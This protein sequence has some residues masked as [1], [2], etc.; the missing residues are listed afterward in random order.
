MTLTIEVII[1]FII[2]IPF[3]IISIFI[4]FGS[5]FQKKVSK[6][7]QKII[8][9]EDKDKDSQFKIFS[10]INFIVWIAVGGVNV[11]LLDNIL[12]LGALIIFLSFRGGATLSRRFV[13]GVHDVKIMKHH[14]SDKKTTKIISFMIKLG[15]IIELLFVLIWGILYRFLSD[16]IKTSLGIDV[17]LLALLLWIAGFIF[18]IIFSAIQ[19]K[20]SNQFLL[21]NEIGIAL[22]VSGVMVKGKV[23]EKKEIIKDKVEEKKEIVKEKVEEKKEIIKEKV[24]EKKK[25]VKDFLKL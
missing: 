6:F 25:K 12:S 15:I 4:S 3:V 7:L 22:V 23:E 10:V 16:T 2:L 17:N 9:E 24:E 11:F 5:L 18:G 13:L 8:K 19:S 20:L 21:K 14:F 1:A